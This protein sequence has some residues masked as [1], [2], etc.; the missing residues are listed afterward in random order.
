[1][2]E[3][4]AAAQF[5]AGGNAPCPSGGG[6]RRGQRSGSTLP[7]MTT[8]GDASAGAGTSSRWRHPANRHLDRRRRGERIADRVTGVFGSWRFIT[9]STSSRC[10]TSSPGTATPTARTARVSA[11]SA[12]PP[13]D[14][15][16]S[17]L[18]TCDLVD[19]HEAEGAGRNC[20]T[21]GV[22][23]GCAQLSTKLRW[24]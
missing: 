9:A 4:P 11:R 21:V 24:R 7:D 20:C 1:M 22:L 5:D 23:P 14:C 3:P 18:V 15:S 12:R 16:P 19:P 13:K 6:A 17:C 10:N 2:P 8:K